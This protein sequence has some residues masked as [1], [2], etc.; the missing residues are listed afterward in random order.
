MFLWVRT[1]DLAFGG[2]TL[3]SAEGSNCYIFF[4]FFQPISLDS[5]QSL[6]T[7][8]H[9]LSTSMAIVGSGPKSCEKSVAEE[10]IVHYNCP[11]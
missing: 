4:S 1:L 5:Q 6:A 3:C 10:N 11:L 9:N 2:C 7:P 8:S